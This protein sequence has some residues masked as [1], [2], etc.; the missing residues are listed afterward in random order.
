LANSGESGREETIDI[1]ENLKNI[2][3]SFSY[4]DLLC[5][6]NWLHLQ[7]P[8][9]FMALD[10][11]C[12]LHEMTP[13][14]ITREPLWQDNFFLYLKLENFSFEIAFSHC[15]V[16]ESRANMKIGENVLRKKRPMNISFSFP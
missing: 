7:T 9:P 3:M 5:Q 2:G 6:S 12:F 11:V 14:G 4:Q 8:I 16:V 13:C 1:D 15:H 10:W